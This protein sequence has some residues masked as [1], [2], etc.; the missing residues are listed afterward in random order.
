[1]TIIIDYKLLTISFHHL[2]DKDEDDDDV[3]DDE[4]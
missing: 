4:G 3:D 2:L 1:M